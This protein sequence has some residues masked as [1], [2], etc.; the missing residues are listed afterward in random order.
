M[1][2]LKSRCPVDEKLI[3]KFQGEKKQ[4]LNRNNNTSIVVRH[5]VRSLFNVR[6]CDLRAHEDVQVHRDSRPL[7]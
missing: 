1:L 4:S 2:N 5:L 6:D 7:Y 3:A